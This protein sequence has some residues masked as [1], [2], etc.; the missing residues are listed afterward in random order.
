SILGIPLELEANI[1]G[2]LFVADRY[3]RSY[4]P[5]EISV[6]QSLATFAALAIENA[7]LLEEGRRALSMARDANA[8]LQ[9]KAED[10]ENA[11]LA[12]ER[13]TELIAR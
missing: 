2:V 10:V 3:E 8:A 5:Q 11:A 4:N 1:I 13:L 6:L 12:H 7:R 9:A